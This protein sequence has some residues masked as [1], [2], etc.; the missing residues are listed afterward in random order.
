M[1]KKSVNED[2]DLGP[3]D[4][5]ASMA[6]AELYKA[7]E[8]AI[9]IFHMIQPGDNLEGWVSAKITKASDYLDSVAHYMEYQK[10]FEQPK[11]NNDVSLDAKPDEALTVE[12]AESLNT[13]WKQFKTQG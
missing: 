2:Q 10:K 3:Q 11:D 13:Q 7:A 6:R 4:H 9:K 1:N 12:V 5:E 8:Y